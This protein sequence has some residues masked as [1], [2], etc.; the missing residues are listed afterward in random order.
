[1]NKNI[2]VCLWTNLYRKI[3]IRR[4]LNKSL[5][6]DSQNILVQSQ[7]MP[8]SPRFVLG[9]WKVLKTIWYLYGESLV[10]QYFWCGDDYCPLKFSRMKMVFVYKPILYRIPKCLVDLQSTTD[11]LQKIWRHRFK[12]NTHLIQFRYLQLT[13]YH[14]LLMR[15]NPAKTK[16]HSQKNLE[17]LPSDKIIYWQ[18]LIPFH[19]WVL[20]KYS[21]TPYCIAITINEIFP[22]Y[23]SKYSLTPAI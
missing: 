9:H 13:L 8:E 21:D 5:S 4:P 20:P 23:M 11:H 7:L 1:M 6:E 22:A 17:T 2:C 19:I 14:R 16:E 15:F 10:A 18:I 3:H 12:R